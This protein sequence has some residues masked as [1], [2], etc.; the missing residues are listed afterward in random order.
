MGAIVS[1]SAYRVVTQL[2]FCPVDSGCGCERAA[3]SSSEYCWRGT[4]AFWHGIVQHFVVEISPFVTAGHVGGESSAA[5][6]ADKRNSYVLGKFEIVG[7]SHVLWTSEAGC[8]SW[9]P[10]PP[11]VV[12]FLTLW[13]RYCFYY[14]FYYL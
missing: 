9:P 7:F 11:P 1:F 3:R 14:L 10:T 12:P 4:A 8:D 13:I 5:F 6:N 2:L